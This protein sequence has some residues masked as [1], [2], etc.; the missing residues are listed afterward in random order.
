[1]TRDRIFAIL[2]GAL[3]NEVAKSYAIPICTGF[4]A[5]LRRAI[6][7]QRS[8]PKFWPT[9]HRVRHYSIRA[10]RAGHRSRNFDRARRDAEMGRGRYI[11]VED[12]HRKGA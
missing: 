8:V 2:F 10:I 11:R 4:D 9:A 1:M 3:R 5:N 7:C 6:R 12:D